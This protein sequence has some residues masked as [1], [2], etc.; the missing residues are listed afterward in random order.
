MGRVRAIRIENYRSI[1]R[2]VVVRFPQNT[3]VVLVGENNAGKSNIVR[4]LD[5]LLGEYWPGSHEPDDHEYHGRRKDEN[6]INIDVWLQGVTYYDKRQNSDRDVAKLSWVYPPPSESKP[7]KMVFSDGD[8]SVWVTNDVR[9]QCSC[10]LVGA[11]RRLSYQLSY[12]SKYTFLAKLMRKFH[13]A[14]TDDELRVQDL[15][16]RFEEIKRIFLEVPEFES[17]SQELKKQVEELSGNLEYSLSI[18]FSAYDPSNYFHALKVHPQEQSE[19]RNIEE[20]GTGQEQILALSFAYAYAKA[21]HDSGGLLLVIEEPEAHLY[22]LAQRWVAQKIRELAAEGVQVVITTHSP[23]FLNILDLEGVVVVRKL[24]GDTSVI[25]RTKKQL[26]EYCQTKGATKADATSILPF[27]AAAATEEILSGFF[28]RKVVLVEGP[29]EATA[30]P[31]YFDRLGLSTNKSGIAVI[32][33][34]GVGNLAKWW[35]MFSAYG[36]PTYVIFD[37]DSN[38]DSKAEK[39]VDLMTALGVP[40]EQWAE[41]MSVEGCVVTPTFC[42]FG[43]NFERT[44]RLGFPKTYRD[45][46]KEAVD[47]IGC[48]STQSK[49]LIARYAA[50]RLDLDDIQP[51]SKWLASLV[52]QIRSLQAAQ[53]TS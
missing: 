41:L 35:R 1:G 4:A 25:Q 8:E 3:P 14:L 34:H 53:D 28:A 30:L 48:G 6:P 43:V 33:V 23:A 7:L 27:Y 36:I 40:S 42:V 9:E 39:R 51:G 13:Q 52:E 32:P 31:V 19:T 24:G 44:M 5:L 20:L 12:A 37:N 16:N 15:Q 45:L 49:P 26:A 22:P 2:R 47:A 17:F 18:D 11:D 38:E 29:T 46:E 21:F 50:E 10:V